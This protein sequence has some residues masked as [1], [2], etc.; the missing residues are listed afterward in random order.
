MCGIFGW[1]TPSSRALDRETLVRLT[2]ILQHRGPDS[3]GYRIETVDGGRWQVA[4]GHRR[5]AIIDLSPGGA[6][7]MSD[8]DD[9][10]LIF[11]GEIYNY[12]ELREE[13]KQHQV[14]FATNSDTEVLLKGLEVWGL[15]CLPKL[16]GMFAF[17]CWDPKTR[18]LILARDPFGKKPLYIAELEQG[19]IAFG[20]ELSALAEF[21]GLD[22]SFDWDSLPEYLVYRYVPGPN[23][24]FRSIKKL[25]P[26]HVAVWKDGALT[27]SRYYDPPYLNAPSV[28]IGTAEATDRFAEV[29]REA[30]QL[31]LRSDAPFG[32]FLSGGI[33]SATIVGLM[34]QELGR[35]VS[36]FSA[37]VQESEHSELPYARLVA[38]HFGTDHEEIT[39]PSSAVFDH[40]PEAVW[41]RGAP[42]SE[43]SDIPILLLSRQASRKVKMVLTG[44]GSDE[45]LGGYPK[46]RFESWISR[47]H[48][49]VPA[50]L[51]DPVASMVLKGLPYGARRMATALRAISERSPSDRMPVWFGA[52]SA[53]TASGFLAHP[54][55]ERAPD[56]YPFSARGSALKRTLFFDQTSWLP[57]NLLERGDRMMMGASIEGR[58]PFMDT[59]LAETVASFPE[60]ALLGAKG[61]KA[62]LRRAVQQ[63]LPAEV[64]TRRK[65]GFRVPVDDWFRTTLR[66]YLHDHLLGPDSQVRLMC[67]QAKL[68]STFE[69]H[70]KG[71]RNHDKLLWALLNLEIFA[72]V[73]RPSFG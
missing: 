44:E 25:G 38:K 2:D 73:Y 54:R 36:T 32:A 33:D 72:R 16:R 55:K 6:Q 62:I 60:S 58:M 30:V 22:R 35:P 15:D 52:M 7:P 40:L 5:L 14:Q 57:D 63:M 9:R 64:L 26:G 68:S 23:T 49:L 3:A 37:G 11:N 4:L 53:A 28:P 69:E 31:R 39:V 42:V 19:G 48:A 71:R 1:A 10:L 29:L 51:H 34:S 27:V 70:A 56:P 21:P 20:S 47:Y 50:S 8:A 45:L 41:H 13:L 17:A 65:V 18:E 67:E 43:P 61:G 59:R 24:F 12:I 66:D 46:H